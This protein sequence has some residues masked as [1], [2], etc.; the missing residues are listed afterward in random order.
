MQQA[1]YKHIFLNPF[2]WFATIW[3]VVLLSYQLQWTTLYRELDITLFLFFGIAIL[4]SL[5]LGWLYAKFLKRQKLTYKHL[6]TKV[7]YSLVLSVSI[8]FLLN[9][10]YAK[11]I[12][13]IDEL[14]NSTFTYMD[15]KGI[16]VFHVLLVTFT[17]F[18][19]VYFYY[20]FL[21]ETL[22]SSQR[23]Y[24]LSSIICFF[25][26]MTLYNRAALLYVIFMC[27]IIRLSMMK[28]IKVRHIFFCFILAVI[29]LWLFGIFGN[30]RSGSSWNDSSYIIEIAQ[31]DLDKYPSFLP[32]EFCWAYV[33][34]VSPLGNL[35]NQVL[36]GVSNFN[37]TGLMYY[38]FPD[39]ISHRIFPTLDTSF[40][41]AQP[42]LN[43]CTGFAGVYKFGGFGG[44]ILMY[45]CMSF[46]IIGIGYLT[47]QN[48]YS[49]VANALLSCIA[50][51]MFFDDF[52]YYTG[53]TFSLFYTCI[54][55]FFNSKR[56][57]IKNAQSCKESLYSTKTISNGS[58]KQ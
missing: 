30:I 47:Q 20:C 44:M 15:F 31:I 2:Y 22:K 16:P 28:K 40:E 38:I 58:E 8:G 34:I 29:L 32:Q 25:W 12:P 10:I 3:I 57:R 5:I 46:M 37:L 1:R 21:C 36:N 26:L 41:L 42:A 33:Y 39:A 48:K 14:T 4:V 24:L 45:V 49:F 7:V 56:N 19:S 27:A 6:S 23:R 53:F 55:I 9:F 35:N 13:L 11:H 43:V 50:I 54:P 18:I 17:V 52:V 51:L